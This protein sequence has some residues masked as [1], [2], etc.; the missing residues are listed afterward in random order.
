MIEELTFDT[1]I[2]ASGSRPSVVPALDIGS[3]RVLDST[4]ALQLQDIPETLLVVGGG[5]IGLEMGSVY[6]E[7]GSKVT[8]AEFTNGLLPGADR[9][10]VK[11]LAKRLEKS[12]HQIMLETKA[13][14]AK[15][16]GDAVEVTLQNAD[17]SNE[18]KERFSR[19]LVSVGRRRTA[20][21]SAWKIPRLSST[22]AVL[23]KPISSNEPLTHTSWR[24]A[25]LLVTRC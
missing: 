17:G 15:D 8:V 22:P 23:S 24:L 18:R 2:L 21:T 4:T 20:T 14:G 5:F 6:A 9:D 10:L 7:L 3:P 19:V 25:M 12:F 13:V 16:V 1:C 11:P